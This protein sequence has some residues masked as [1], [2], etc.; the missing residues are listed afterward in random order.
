M[1]IYGEIAKK[2]KN[3]EFR[4]NNLYIKNYPTNHTKWLYD[5]AM[6]GIVRQDYPK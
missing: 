4:R 3:R 2:S 5:P 6:A 1:G